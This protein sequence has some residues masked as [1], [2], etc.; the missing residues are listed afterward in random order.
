MATC[1]VVGDVL[2][3]D[4]HRGLL[5][6]DFKVS[7]TCLL[8]K[9]TRSKVSGPD[10]HLN[11]RVVVIH[12]SAYVQHKNWLSTGWELLLKGAP[13][14]R[15]YPLP[16][17]SNN[18]RGF[19]TKELKYATAF[20]V[21]TQIIS[22]ASYRGLKIFQGSTGHYYTPHSGRNF[23][24]SGTAVLGFSQAD[25]DILGGWSAEGSERYT[26]TAKYKIAQ[27][28]SAIAATFRNP[29]ADQLGEADDIDDLGDFLT[30]W[31]V[32]EQSILRTK[33][34]LWSR[35]FSDLERV[36]S[37]EPST[38]DVELAAGEIVLD[39]IDE[40]AAVKKNLARQKQQSGNRERSELLGSDDKQTGA[41]IRSNLQEGYYI[42]HSGKKSFRVL[43]FLGRCCMLPG[44][45][46][47]SFTFGGTSFPD[48][49]AY[50][51]V[52]KWCAKSAELKDVPGSSGTN[53][54][55]SSDD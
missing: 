37:L 5:P 47:Q 33:K 7:E 22:L 3:F 13:D 43:H 53:T 11:F 48:S 29:D 19:K 49:S 24:P 23:M 16:A 41:E 30:T 51:T 46:Y 32:P 1:T 35:T 44:V 4:D 36:I 15:D 10:K 25:R 6:R 45:D 8:A 34:I 40:E 55:S 28:Q 14:E 39:D 26:R 9:L 12:A 27:M 54:S 52:C 2:R 42:S 20:A 21:Q 31:E 38:V 17:P 50:D 18:Y